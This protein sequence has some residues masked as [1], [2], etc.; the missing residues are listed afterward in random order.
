MT[1]AE[2]KIRFPEFTTLTDL[3]VQAAI[4]EAVLEVSAEKWSTWYNRGLGYLAAHI[5]KLRTTIEGGDGGLDGLSPVASKTVGDVSVSFAAGAFLAT[6]ADGFNATPY[7]REFF[8]LRKLISFGG[9][10]A[11]DE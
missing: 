4:D 9:I 7:G 1:P 2:F 3:K 8:R 5:L 6:D 10:V 11:T